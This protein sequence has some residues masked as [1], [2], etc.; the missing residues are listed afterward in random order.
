MKK[1]I[2]RLLSFVGFLFICANSAV[3]A[4]TPTVTNFTPLST[5]VGTFQ[6]FEA[7]FTIS[8]TFP[9]DSLL[10]YYFYDPAD[11]SA[12][13]P[14]RN[15]PYGIDGISVD[16]HFT[17]PSGKT[18]VV[19]AFYYQ[20]YSRT[21]SYSSGITLTPTN[22]FNWKVR[23]APSEVGFYD[24][25]VT[26][27][28][29]NGTTRYPTAN[30]MQLTA[31]SSSSK[32][33]IKVSAQDKRFLE[34]TN[35]DAFIP[36]SSGKQ[37]WSCCGKRSFDFEKTFTDF[38]LN[39]VNFTRIW[40]QNDGYGLTVEGKYDGYKYPDD[41]P[42]IDT[43]VNIDAIQKGTQFNQRGN[44]EEDKIIESA[45]KNGVYIQL[46][47]HG[48]PYWIWDGS[49]Y[50]ESWNKTPQIFGSQR[51]LSYWK[52][53]FR[54][55]VARWGYSTSVFGWEAW[56]EHGHITPGMDVY[57]FYSK[58][59][60]Y[61]LQTDPY[62]H[63]RTTSQG[64]QAFSP[65]FWS[66]GFFDVANYHNY[67][68]GWF[69]SDLKNDEANFVYRQA[70]CLR[71][72]TKLTSGSS[73]CNDLGL[74]DGTKWSTTFG[75]MP[76][77]WGEIDVGTNTWNEPNPLT[78]TGEGRVR[79][80]HNLAWSGLFSPLGTTPIDWYWEGEDV[81]TIANKLTQKKAVSSFFKDIKYDDNQMVY[82]MSTSDTPPGYIG[83]TVDVTNSA[84]RVY[85]MKSANKQ[86]VYGWIQNKNNTW[87]NSASTTSPINGK[88]T[89]KG[90][91]TSSY[92]V[93]IWNTYTGQITSSTVM[94]PVNGLLDINVSNLTNDFAVKMI[95]TNITP[96]P[97][98]TPTPIPSPTP[99]PVTSPTPTPTPAITATPTPTVTPSAIGDGDVNGDSTVS[100]I[101]ITTLLNNWNS[102]ISSS[103]DQ[104]RDG[105]VNGLDFAVVASALTA[106]TPT[107]SPTPTITPTPTPVVTP[108]PTPVPTPTPIP[109]AT[110]GSWNQFGG[111]AQR[112]NFTS[113]TVQTPW[114]FKWQW[115][116][117]DANG[118]P[119]SNHL[120]VQD[121]VQPVSGGSRVYIVANNTVY[122][123]DKNSTN[124]V[125][126]TVLWSKSGLGNLNSTV[127]YANEF[128]YVT[129][130]NGLQKLDAS[131]GSVAGTYNAN[132][133]LKFA[134]LINGNNVVVAADNGH[135]IA[136]DKNSLSK[137]WEYAPTSSSTSATTASY[138]ASKNVYV[139]ITQDLKVHAV[140]GTNG[141]LKWI[142]K[143]T[144]R[145]YGDPSTTNKSLAQA[146]EGW[147]V[148]A[149]NHGIVFVRYR[150]DWQTLWDGPADKATFPADNATARKFLA[151]NPA[152]QAL[153]ALKLDDGAD[154]FTTPPNAGN[155]GAGDGGYLPM[156]PQPIVRVVDGK[157]VAY[158]LF[159]NIQ[160]CS[161]ES[162]CDGREDTTM[163]EMVLDNS[164]VTGLSGGDVRFVQ[165]SD[166]KNYNTPPADPYYHDM[167]TDEMMYITGSGDTLFHNHWLASE[168]YTITDRSS[169]LGLS[170]I[171]PIKTTH[172][173]NVIWRQVYCPTSNT[174]C[175]P[176]IYPG[177]T[178]TNYGPAN[179]PFNAS[180]RYCASGLY[181]YGDS[182]AY[183]PGFYE[184]HN[185]YNSNDNSKPFVVVSDGLVLIKT[186]DGAVIALENGSPTASIFADTIPENVLGAQTVSG[187]PEF[188]YSDAKDHIG[189]NIVIKATVV[190][191]ENNMPKAYYIGF[192]DNPHETFLVRVFAKDV[193]KFGYDLSTLKGKTIRISGTPS[194][195]WPEGKIA[196]L[197]V[198]SPEQ[199]SIVDDSV[200]NES[201]VKKFIKNI[202]GKNGKN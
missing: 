1:N 101:D 72:I 106:V 50:D 126:G 85:A 96:T 49:T 165:W 153:F 170:Y 114:R 59:S 193:S 199:I 28:D 136:I 155:G 66:S 141:S 135:L 118:Q 34:F 138:S 182:R 41:Y 197:V 130:S 139:Y 22:N 115:N 4:S 181:G 124:K 48:D 83:E 195:Y 2:V 131:N 56:N 176:A 67:M 156:G 109:E 102:T 44:Y 113:Q 19:P 12:T 122:A 148:I 147:P 10:P 98:P 132:S 53:N 120:S 146:E 105:K 192:S 75:N 145:N 65:A 107:P 23:F 188:S 104:Y 125:N 164:T 21:G 92:K 200:E 30:S 190:S 142:R 123:L 39:G 9:T 175:N 46:T 99:T 60:S 103:T 17:A 91:G 185:S 191:V 180:S 89:F 69:S 76:W 134:P 100:T 93:E 35:G 29:K 158:M 152:Q 87:A 25:Y 79:M 77:V 128:V 194:L 82:T 74:G 144:V 133:D 6:K 143:P 149:E 86:Y 97:T 150:L 111:N 129:S 198:D 171:Q 173:P 73:Y 81:S 13:D 45:E 95:S 40:D 16:V 121:L 7:N 186:N 202:F 154:A 20:D 167:Q 26:I 57:N 3:A 110:S 18:L 11:N 172:A 54:Y 119:Q 94:T 68:M 177:G 55:R 80:L 47:S 179:C 27:T 51:H 169:G 157:E 31:T 137:V 61:Q 196:E 162:W 63:L 116:G 24:Y 178:G 108:T 117:S 88:A 37:W 71:D 189:E 5:S 15:S 84:I 163:G 140:N 90:L 52:R 14:G 187:L 42:P 38:G 168:A 36:V 159:R 160:T 62:K 33:F 64:S 127:A 151:D 8:Q 183:A 112:T 184:Y 58:Y 174:Q 166:S 78:K 32:G 201:G 70:W 43:G 161:R